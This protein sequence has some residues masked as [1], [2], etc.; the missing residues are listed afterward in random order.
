MV[1][2]VLLAVAV[3]ASPVVAGDNSSVNPGFSAQGD[4][5]WEVI[6]HVLA[7][8]K[9]SDVILGSGRVQYGNRALSKASCN[10]HASAKGDLVITVIAAA[11]CPFKGET[12]ETCSITV[13]K[14]RRGSFDF[15]VQG[16][17]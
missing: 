2:R 16:G 17:R 5:N 3:L 6:C 13:P 8:G 14:L 12:V 10:Y 11:K 15:K 4:G 1:L 9:Q 7:D